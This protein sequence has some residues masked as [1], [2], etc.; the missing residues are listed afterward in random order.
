[1][2][3]LINRLKFEMH[4]SDEWQAFNLRENFAQTFQPQIQQIIDRVCAELVPE[5]QL[6]RIDRL[7]IEMGQF[8]PHSFGAS[9]ESV[10]AYKFEQ[11]L[12][13]QLVRNTPEEK[14]GAV[15]VSA[16]EAFEFFLETGSLPWWI[17]DKDID[18]AALNGAVFEEASFQI[19][20]FFDSQRENVGLWMRAAWQIPAATK[21][22]LIQLFPELQIALHLL[23]KWA[24]DF[25]ALQEVQDTGIV[26]SFP[27]EVFRELVLLH[28]PAIFNSSDVSAV[29]TVLWPPFAALIQKQAAANGVTDVAVQNM[30][31]ALAQEENISLAQSSGQHA[32][33]VSMP[34]EQVFDAPDERY[35]VNHAGIILLAPFFKQ[36]FEQLE[37]FKD[38]EWTS[39]EAHMKAVH[40]LGFLSTG[41]QQLPEY[42]LSLEK[43]ICGMPVA[44]PIRM[45]I[46]LN[47]ADIAHCNDLLQAVISHWTV[48]KNTSIDG[49]RGNFLV[50]DGVLTTHENGWQLRVERRTL[51]VLLDQLPWGFTT[52]AFPWRQDLILTEW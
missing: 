7:E 20:L 39:F 25:A 11:A 46:E 31:A 36:F 8:S 9:F 4:C 44:M 1:M 10:F 45:D 27:D 33:I 2:Q 18:F 15:Q 40:L 37:L 43:I 41:V 26:F 24:N 16:R 35:F 48:L 29:S 13:G 14:Q 51:D 49:L 34:P 38:G 22:I 47:E 23:V 50:R 5:D 3:H 17:S 32:P 19:Q 12:R 21:A 42:A 28:A 52:A 30:T 6:V